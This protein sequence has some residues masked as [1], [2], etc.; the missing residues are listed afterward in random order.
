MPDEAVSSS[1]QEEV[2]TRCKKRRK[3]KPSKAGG[4]KLPV[5]WKRERETGAVV[6]RDCWN[7]RYLLRTLTFAIASPGEGTW[8]DLDADLKA[9]WEQTTAASNWM[10]TQCYVRDIHRSDAYDKM[11]P[12]RPLYLY[13]EARIL[14]PKLPPTTVVA[15]ERAVQSTY[16]AK[17]YEVIW[18]RSATLPSMRY[19]Q[20]FPVH[21]QSWS[22]SFDAGNRPWIKC[23]LNDRTW[24][25][26]LKSGPRY[27]RQIAGL[28]NML[29]RS[30]LSIFKA[31]DGTVLCKLVGW[32]GREEAKAATGTLYVRTG[33]DHLLSAIDDADKRLW[34][35]NCDHL[36]R[37]IAEY[38]RRLRR[39]SEDQKAEQQPNPAFSG[40]RT[41][42]VTKHRHRIETTIKEVAAHLAGF[43]VRRRI[44][45]VVYD[46]RER[47]LDPF[48]YFN[49]QDRIKTVLE[50]RSIEFEKLAAGSE[51]V[52]EQSGGPLRGE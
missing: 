50:E 33:K 28:R 4:L 18:T 23:R 5:G 37:L 1:T 21:N 15:L 25:L 10:M 12:M 27:R 22:F 31:H 47:W 49:L 34:I 19:P 20:P 6:C 38:T 39:L 48:P 9:M 44:A 24:E 26:R 40:H 29:E 17:R 16:R 52:A 3:T 13:P 43:A 46:D 42:M 7:R 45:R 11:P 30:E 35:E 51:M 36:P 32:L 2:C 14:F 41:A 8:K